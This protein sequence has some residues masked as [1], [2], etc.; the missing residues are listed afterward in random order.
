MQMLLGLN[1]LTIYMFCTEMCN[2]QLIKRC[3][4]YVTI[5]SAIARASF[6]YGALKYLFIRDKYRR[7]AAAA[8]VSDISV[9]TK[10][11]T[12]ICE[13]CLLKYIYTEYIYT[14][15]GYAHR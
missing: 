3:V 9:M 4:G 1:E 6:K 13:V 15:Q 14:L 10:V 7:S 2:G 8:S 5:L 11:N 12:R